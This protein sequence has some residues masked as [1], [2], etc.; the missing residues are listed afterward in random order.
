MSKFHEF[1]GEIVYND[2]MTY[3]K[4]AESMI[5]NKDFDNNSLMS[6]FTI[7]YESMI[8]KGP[9]GHLIFDLDKNE[10][11]LW[12]LLFL[13]QYVFDLWDDRLK[14]NERCTDRVEKQ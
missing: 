9:D 13:R 12:N 3:D 2:K 7:K 5:N 14:V 4:I 6:R 1:A 8:K 11:Q 10:D